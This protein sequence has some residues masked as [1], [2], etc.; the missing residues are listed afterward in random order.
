[1]KALQKF[2]TPHGE[3]II[4]MATSAKDGDEFYALMGRWFAS[5]EV[6]NSLG[7]PLFDNENVVWTLAVVKNH[8][9]GFG[10]ID[11]SHMSKHWALLNYGFMQKKYRSTGIYRRLLEARIKLVEDDTDAEEIRA[12]CTADSAPTLAK[13]GF[14]E[15]SHRGRYTWFHREVKR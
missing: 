2:M 10:G 6:A 12:L 8:V 5:K 3:C 13:L 15:G 7:E 14:K 4:W 11:L 1:M 9:V